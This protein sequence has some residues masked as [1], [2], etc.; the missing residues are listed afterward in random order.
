MS[1]ILFSILVILLIAGSAFSQENIQ[2]WEDYYEFEENDDLDK[3]LVRIYRCSPDSLT[4]AILDLWYENGFIKSIPKPGFLIYDDVA[5]ETSGDTVTYY[6]EDEEGSIE[7]VYEITFYS[8]FIVAISSWGSERVAK[9]SSAI[10]LVYYNEE[11]D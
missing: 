3:T 11:L 6:T 10:P 7:I 5:V 8:D 9:I 1:K 2:W 4:V